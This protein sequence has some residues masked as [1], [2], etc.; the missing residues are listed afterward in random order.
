RAALDRAL[1]EEQAVALLDG[2]GADPQPPRQ[3]PHRREPPARAVGALGDL[4]REAPGH[5]RVERG[6]G[7][8]VQYRCRGPGPCS[9]GR[10]RSVLVDISLSCI[11]TAIR[12]PPS[13][14]PSKT[15]GATMNE[16]V[17]T[18]MNGRL[19]PAGEAAVPVLDHG[20]LYGDGIFE[21]IRFYGGVPFR[22][23]AHLDRLARSAAALALPLPWPRS[24][25]VEAVGTVIGAAGRPDGY[26]RLVVTRGAGAFG[27]DPRSC[28]RPNLLLA[29]G[30]FPAF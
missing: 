28:E 15:K 14:L 6:T 10:A 4:G 2:G 8:R 20:L 1:V 29:T 24:E 16:T 25:L 11:C 26:I 22:L 19:L 17:T 21:G 3:L 18:W 9:H 12:L 27:L 13:L 30:S 23:G 5:G 7:L